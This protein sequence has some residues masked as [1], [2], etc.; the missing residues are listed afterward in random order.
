MNRQVVV[1]GTGVFSP[2]GIGKEHYNNALAEGS[3]GFGTIT[4]FNT[5]DF[6]FHIA[7]EV[8]DF[9]P[10]IYLGKKGLRD[11]D[12]ST[13]LV[14]S[15]AKLAIED[16]KLLITDENTNSI[17]V[18]IGSTFGSL[19]SISQ[20]DR[21]GLIEGPKCVNPSHFPNTILN[22]PASRISIYFGIKG[23]NTTISTGF[24]AS[25]DAV[26]YAADFIKL[27][28]VNAVLAGGVEEL[29]E[30]MFLCF[31][32]LGWL[33]GSDGSAPLSCPFDAR[34]SGFVFS[35]GTVVFALEEKEYALKRGANINAV[36]KGYG[37]AFSPVRNSDLSSADKN[38]KDDAK[39]LAD[40]IGIALKDASLNPQDISCVFSCANSTK[41]LDAVE[42]EAIK[43]VFNEYAYKIPTTSIKSMIGESY[44]ASGGFALAAAVCAITDNFIP[45]TMNYKEQDPI[46]DL[47]YVTGTP[48][49]QEIDNALIL[50][51]DPYGQNNAMIIGKYNV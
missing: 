30:E 19:H 29:C 48:K 9:D 41:R 36:I 11:L 50:S 42:T 6:N 24:C 18:C 25:L 49:R 39:G 26:S 10:V 32:A 33:S 2:L 28:R 5:S 38:L 51:A 43:S 3:S 20:F 35:E 46:C 15:A 21:A 47:N 22:S 13:R 44:S 31:N 4:L 1:T 23:F 7:G 40:A 14:C 45:A 12:R 37:N 27:N 17:G 8:K 34:R 16:S